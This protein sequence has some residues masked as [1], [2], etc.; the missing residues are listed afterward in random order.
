MTLEIFSWEVP[1]EIVPALSRLLF[2]VLSVSECLQSEGSQVQVL[3]QEVPVVQEE[4]EEEAAGAVGWLV[5]MIRDTLL[6]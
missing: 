3:A 1:L 5:L 4:Q 2:L 6:F